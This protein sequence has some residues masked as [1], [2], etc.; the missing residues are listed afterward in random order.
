MQVSK[1]KPPEIAAA[2]PGPD[3]EVVRLLMSLSVVVMVFGL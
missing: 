1:M 2:T 3:V